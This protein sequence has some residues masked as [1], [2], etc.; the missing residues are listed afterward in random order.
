MS[1]LRTEQ[2]VPDTTGGDRLLKASEVAALLSVST[3]LVWRLRA[4]GELP[5]VTIGR[6]TRFRRS[7]VERIIAEGVK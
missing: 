2:A 3:R 4:T 1:T 7:D 5:A 6:S